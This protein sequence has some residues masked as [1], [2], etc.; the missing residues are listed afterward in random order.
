[1]LSMVMGYWSRFLT[2]L[3]KN[4]SCSNNNNII[5]FWENIVTDSA[6]LFKCFEKNYSEKSSKNIALY[7][8]FKSKC[9]SFLTDKNYIDKLFIIN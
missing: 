3:H 4:I 7:T 6:N 9:P 5:T 8:R 1:M 2:F